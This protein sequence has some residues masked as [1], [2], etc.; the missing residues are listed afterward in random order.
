M[1]KIILITILILALLVSAAHAFDLK[2]ENNTDRRLM[3][4]L[5]WLACDWE[6]YPRI[7]HRWQGE[8][9][10]GEVLKA[11]TDYKPGPYII[12]WQSLFF[13]E[14]KFTRIYPFRV[15]PGKN[16]SIVLSLPME[17]PVLIPGT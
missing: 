11:G 8:I 17:I 10:A 13:D 2:L 9:N 14:D 3:F 6:G 15:E 16:I 4:R 12:K 7:L 5:T 1:K